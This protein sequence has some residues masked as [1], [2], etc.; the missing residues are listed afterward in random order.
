MRSLD[1][2]GRVILSPHF[3]DVLLARCREGKLVLTTYD[4]CV[5]GFPLPDWEV[6]EERLVTLNSSARE[7]RD[8]QR[9]LLGGVE[10]V[11]IDK[12]G[13]LQVSQA[14]REYA[15]LSKDIMLVGMLKRFEIWDKARYDA[16][17]S[18][19]FD[20]VYGDLA[21]KGINLF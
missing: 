19:D 2:K 1:D 3:R 8:L 6:I 17:T 12:Q 18:R 7:I 14:H 15:G 9:L 20:P 16:C 5:V 21:E 13:R 10:M 11:S 4:Q